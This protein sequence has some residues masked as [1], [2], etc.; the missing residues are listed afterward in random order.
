MCLWK[1]W[2]VFKWST[3]LNCSIHALWSVFLSNTP[4]GRIC[5]C[6]A[7]PL[8]ITAVKWS[9]YRWQHCV[10]KVSLVMF[11]VKIIKVRRPWSSVINIWLRLWNH[12]DCWF[13][14]EIE[15]QSSVFT[16]DVLLIYQSTTPAFVW[17]LSFS[18]VNWPSSYWLP[19][20]LKPLDVDPSFAKQFHPCD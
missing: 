6:L 11:W 14:I 2:Q 18:D 4:V 3:K 1:A 9:S 13:E 16:F 10:V 7:K 15:Q 20:F 19:Y 5:L 12:L 17:N 8:Q